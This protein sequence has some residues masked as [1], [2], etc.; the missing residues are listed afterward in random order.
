MAALDT[1]LPAPALLRELQRIECAL[2]RVRRERWGAR[3]IDLDLVQLGTATLHTPT[4][5]LPHPGLRHRD[6]WQRELAELA[7]I[8][9]RAA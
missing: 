2:G 9:R 3:T 1:A 6:F 8:L 5:E 7:S 4:L